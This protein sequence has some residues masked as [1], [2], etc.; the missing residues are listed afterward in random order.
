MF[1]DKNSPDE[2]FS[3]SHMKEL[4]LQNCVKVSDLGLQH[5]ATKCNDLERIN[6]QGLPHVTDSGIINLAKYC[7]LLQKIKLSGSFSRNVIFPFLS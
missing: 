7:P 3:T 5:I 6:L 4:D 2:S 1:E